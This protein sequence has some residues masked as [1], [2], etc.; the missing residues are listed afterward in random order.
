M[1]T[2]TRT[3]TPPILL[4]AV[5][6]LADASSPRLDAEGTT[7]VE[8][9]PTSFAR[10]FRRSEGT[11]PPLATNSWT[12]PSTHPGRSGGENTQLISG[13]SAAP[14]THVEPELTSFARPFRRLWG[15]GGHAIAPNVQSRSR[16]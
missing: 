3:D 8:P 7:D 11:W 12:R 10:P 9:D 1:L 15:E 13:P 5:G 14:P 2:R 6:G 16:Y 4:G